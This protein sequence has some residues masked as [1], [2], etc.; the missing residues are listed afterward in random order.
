MEC[1]ECGARVPSR[2]SHCPQCDYPITL[3]D[4]V[5]AT[6]PPPVAKPGIH[7]SRLGSTIKAKPI[8]P[9]PVDQTKEDIPEA[10]ARLFNQ[11]GVPDQA[12][13]DES[14]LEDGIQTIASKLFGDKR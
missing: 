12:V 1:P 8:P 11:T 5:P 7:P 4:S 3:A 6:E 2:E 14:N 10:Q 13:P 9:A